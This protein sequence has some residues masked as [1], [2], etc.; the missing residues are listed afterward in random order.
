MNNYNL[1]S[2]LTFGKFK[3]K[4]ISEILSER[5]AYINWCIENIPTFVV[6]QEDLEA[7]KSKF[8]EFK[9]TESQETILKRKIATIQNS[10]VDSGKTKEPTTYIKTRSKLARFKFRIETLPL[11]SLQTLPKLILKTYVCKMIQH[12]GNIKKQNSIMDGFNLTMKIVQ[13]Q[14]RAQKTKHNQ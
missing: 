12:T 6:L 4:T 7:M 9:T 13:T 1:N 3:R 10:I 8:P 2:I 14:I 5:P 11:T